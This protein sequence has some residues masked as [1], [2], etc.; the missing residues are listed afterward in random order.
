LLTLAVTPLQNYGEETGKL[1]VSS[2]SEQFEGLAFDGAN[3]WVANGGSNN[4]T[5]LRASDGKNLGTF[6]VGTAPNAVAFDGANVWITNVTDGTVTKL[7]ASD[8]KTLGTFSDGGVGG[9]G[10]AFDGVNMWII[11]AALFLLLTLFWSLVM[12]IVTF[13]GASDPRSEV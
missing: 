5:K 11:V 12:D 2:Q 7:R 10:I 6:T 1:W 4:V 9:F 8:G 13:L 3:V